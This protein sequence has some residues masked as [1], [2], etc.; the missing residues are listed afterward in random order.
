MAAVI[1]GSATGFDPGSMLR[2]VVLGGVI[3]VVVGVL[4]L[5][6]ADRA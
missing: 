3:S 6:M 2:R 4:E 5:G 1:A